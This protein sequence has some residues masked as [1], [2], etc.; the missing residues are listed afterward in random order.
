[1]LDAGGKTPHGLL[2]GNINSVGMFE[3]CLGIS[4]QRNNSRIIKGKYCMA[5][6]PL[7]SGFLGISA[8]DIASFGKIFQEAPYLNHR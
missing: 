1:M 3:E 5:K 2:E 6:I 8:D 4:H 7:P